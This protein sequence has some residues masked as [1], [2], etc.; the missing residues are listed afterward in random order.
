[1]ISQPRLALPTACAL[2]A[3]GLLLLS[4]AEADAG[5]KEREE[6]RA[7]KAAAEAPTPGG[8]NCKAPAPKDARLAA[9][10]EHYLRGEWN[11]ALAPLRA[12][13]G[14]PDA[15][16]DPA[17]GRGYYSLGYA[18]TAT[19]RPQAST[20]WYAKA[21]P[22]LVK[23]AE[24]NPNLED[25]YYLASLY[26]TRREPG[27]QLDVVSRALGLLESGKLCPATDGDDDFRISRL[28]SFA[29]RDEER[30]ARLRSAVEKYEQGLGSVASYHALALQELGETARRAGDVATWEAN[31]RKATELDPS[32]PNVHRS[33]GL[34]LLQRGALAEAAEYWRKNWRRERSNGNALIYGVRV[35]LTNSR[36]AERFGDEHRIGNLGEHTKEA[37]EENAV[38]EARQ[39]AEAQQALASG[40]LGPEE[41]VAKEL[42]RDVA[43]YR[44]SQFLTEYVKRELD[45][46]EFAL[47]N[48]LLPA[49]HGSNLPRR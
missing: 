22:L 38:F 4:C 7:A 10:L 15:A 8:G 37:L 32:I 43:H 1:M 40:T 6:R 13:A 34:A 14:E 21:E 30:E 2:A 26:R 5:K 27:K 33:L 28:L 46:S 44:L 45:L 31:L 48:G 49:I 20:A 41:K 18:M 35:L 9:G 47:Q 17:A 42:A 3:S 36:Y 23:S 29:G 39:M 24:E 11:E 25:L 12:W 19:R 16:E